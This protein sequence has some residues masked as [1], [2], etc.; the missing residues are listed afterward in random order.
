MKLVKL[1]PK[2][3]QSNKDRPCTSFH[4]YVLLIGLFMQSLKSIL[5]NCSVLNALWDEYATFQFFLA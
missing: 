5:D 4:I 2:C 3:V 1:S